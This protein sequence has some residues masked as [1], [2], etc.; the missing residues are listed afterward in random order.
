MTYQPA[1]AEP[2]QETPPAA[3]P[4]DTTTTPASSVLEPRGET[5]TAL[6]S[7]PP[8]DWTDPDGIA[9][10]ILERCSSAVVEG[11]TQKLLSSL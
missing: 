9:A 7:E 6:D 5:N 1:A 4:A 11:I 2:V 8:L 10:A 3:A